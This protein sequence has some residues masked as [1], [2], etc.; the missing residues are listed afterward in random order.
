MYKLLLSL[1]VISAICRS[2][3]PN[4]TTFAK[5]CLTHWISKLPVSF[6]IHWVRQYLINLIGLAGIVN[7]MVCKT[8]PNFTGV[9]HGKLSQFLTL[10]ITFIHDIHKLQSYFFVWQLVW[11]QIINDSIACHTQYQDGHDMHGLYMW[12]WI[13]ECNQM[14]TIVSQTLLCS[15]IISAVTTSCYE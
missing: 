15:C 1:M 8:K 9:W 10:S 11:Q 3:I 5:Y 14:F 2:F 6:E 4:R 12:I 13:V 7:A